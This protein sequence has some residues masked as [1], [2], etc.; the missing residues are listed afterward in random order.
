MECTNQEENVQKNMDF[1]PRF[2]AAENTLAK[3]YQTLNQKDSLQLI[4]EGLLSN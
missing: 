2:K 3:W 1:F 4:L